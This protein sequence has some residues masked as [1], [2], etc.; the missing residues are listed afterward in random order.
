LALI[1]PLATK[2]ED[3]SF[4]NVHRLGFASYVATVRE[5]LVEARSKAVIVTPFI[6][7]AGIDFL[8]ECWSNRLGKDCSWEV[9]VRSVDRRLEKLASKNAWQL[10]EY[11]SAGDAGMHAKV[12]SAD[13][14]RV[15]LGSMNLLSRNMHTNLE[16][17]VDI[18][19]D[20]IVWKL[21]RLETWLKKASKQ[22][23]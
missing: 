15:I 16:L 21:N 8:Q 1:K 20:P 11:P 7:D 19:D 5:A 4:K 18:S 14:Q 6:D 9:Y 3:P 12:V 13:E 17:G 2:S 10:Y 23:V 22:R